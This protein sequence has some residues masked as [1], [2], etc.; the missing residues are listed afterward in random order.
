MFDVEKIMFTV[1][2]LINGVISMTF[3]IKGIVEIINCH[4]KKKY[5]L[6]SGEI[7]DIYK[8]N[9]SRYNTRE[10]I[11]L[12]EYNNTQIRKFVK[13]QSAK[14]KYK[15]GDKVSVYYRPGLEAKRIRVVGET[16]YI[17][18]IALVL[19]GLILLAGALLYLIS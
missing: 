12:F 14:V 7:V 5:Q 11:V 8:Y 16:N 4:N 6:I 19:L 9:N 18:P 1:V 3:G 17:G 15:V 13:V 2:F 10:P